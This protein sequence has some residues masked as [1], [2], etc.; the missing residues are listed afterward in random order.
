MA[1]ADV[2]GVLARLFTDAPFRAS[3][4]A[5]PV[6]VGRASGLD[7]AEAQVLSELSRSEVDGFAATLRRKRVADVRSVLPLTARAL[8]AAFGDLTR[9]AMAG[10]SRPGRHHDDARAI[11][12]RLRGLARS[13]QLEPPWVADLARYEATFG[14]A[15]RRRACLLVRRFHFPIAALAVA[16]LGGAPTADVKPCMTVGIW[17]RWPGRCGVFHRLWHGGAQRAKNSA[18]AQYHPAT[19]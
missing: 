8:G 4:F 11:V 18:D 7:P 13:Y 6:A 9:P 2:Q 17:V 16:I 3:F 10:A 14:L 5:D 12:D 15:Q 19:G 1:L